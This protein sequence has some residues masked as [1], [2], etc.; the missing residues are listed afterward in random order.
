MKRI[1]SK[2]H[3]LGTYDVCRTTLSCFDYKRYLL[4]DCDMILHI[5]IE[6]LIVNDV[7]SK[8]LVIIDS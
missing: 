2:F 7:I 5:S 4:D 1:L 3:R 8:V 6:T